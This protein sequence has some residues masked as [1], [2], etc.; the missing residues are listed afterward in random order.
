MLLNPNTG[1]EDRKI[2][3]E[4]YY[5]VRAAILRAVNATDGLP[6]SQLYDLVEADT[7][8]ALWENSSVAWYTVGVKLDLEARGLLER[9]GSPQQLYL[10]SDGHAA[11]CEL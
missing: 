4:M 11:L 3:A 9:S 7:D 2:A 1:R 6:F 5:P 8:A 10:T